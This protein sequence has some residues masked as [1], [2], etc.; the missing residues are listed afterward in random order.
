MGARAKPTGMTAA[1]LGERLR[2]RISREGPI[3]VADYMQACLADARAGYYTSR[4]PIGAS[5][6][7]ITS[8]EVSQIFGELIGLWAVT[9]WHAMGKPRSVVVAELG[10]GRGTLLADAS[11]AWRSQPEFAD[12]VSLALVET[13]PVL[14]GVQ[15]TTLK[16]SD[17]PMQWCDR[18]E[19]VAEG[20]PLIVL[21]NEFID[22]LPVRQLVR[23]GGDWRE[24]CIGLD[25]DARLAFVDGNIVEDDHL[26]AEPDG[27]IVERRPGT[28]ALL[29]ALAKRAAKAPLAALVIDYGHAKSGIGDTLQAVR[30]HRYADPLAE[31]GAADLTA[32]VDFAALK[33]EA[34]ALALRTYGPMP[35]GEFLL[36]LGLLE[37]RDRLLAIAP[38]EQREL[39]S[40]GATRLADPGQMGVLFKVLALTSDGLAPP[41][42][43]GDI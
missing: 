17:R 34:E 3:S 12:R 38:A 43:F 14:R 30:H 11:R 24:R 32:Q 13:S 5:G 27:A 20:R 39:I 42:P 9:V 7:F 26:P 29:A 35:Q 10:P 15:R 4:E 22:A 1:T 18:I 16:V 36:R 28:A 31:P 8:P 40:S 33:Q 2:A 37:R 41:P 23:R 25:Q 19:D 21:A 6:D